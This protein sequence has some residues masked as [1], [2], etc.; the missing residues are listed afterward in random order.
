MEI[1]LTLVFLVAVSFL[2]YTTRLPLTL[3]P[4]FCLYLFPRFACLL[5]RT[6]VRASVCLPALY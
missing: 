2:S 3:L 5:L 4:M 6:C 1:L